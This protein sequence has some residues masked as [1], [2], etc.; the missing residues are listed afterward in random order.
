MHLGCSYLGW[1]QIR[2]TR[3]EAALCSTASFDRAATNAFQLYVAES[4]AFTVKR[5]GFLYGNPQF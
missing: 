3:Q 4:L 2:V 5:V 1:H